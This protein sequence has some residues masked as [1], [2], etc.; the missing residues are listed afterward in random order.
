MSFIK[1][2][3]GAAGM[4]AFTS[5]MAQAAEP[6]TI[7]VVG[8]ITGPAAGNGA[9]MRAGAIAAADRINAQGGIHGQKLNLRFEDDACS[10]TQAI[11]VANRIIGQ[12]DKFVVGHYCSNATLP[13]SVIYDENGI[14]QITLSQATSITQQ[15]FPRLFRIT[16]SAEDLANGYITAVSNDIK[17]A[18]QA[19]LAL[20][21]NSGEYA[22]SIAKSL[23]KSLQDKG[24]ELNYTGHYPPEDTDYSAVITRMRGARITH[25]M[26]AGSEKEMGMIVRQSAQHGFH[27]S[28]ILSS[29]ALSAGFAGIVSCGGNGVRAVAAD[30]PA[31]AAGNEAL[32]ADLLRHGA[33]GLDVAMFSYTA[34]E[35][36]AQAF[37][38]AGNTD[39]AAVSNALHTRTFDLPTG[40]TGFTASGELTHPRVIT[41][42]YQ[43]VN[44][45][46][47]HV[48]P[49]PLTP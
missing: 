41:Y 48:K 28:F 3:F 9:D 26:I 23:Q 34:V 14:V 39:A 16:P 33:N 6:Y 40:K 42:Q 24:I 43:S 2:I 19:K 32:K 27:P 13:A 29:T 11:N 36:F 37:K 17:A 45:P 20:I 47:T 38:A 49:V 7:T 25:V 8:P 22:Q 1:Y 21:G 5:G 31:Y 35:A 12:G 10:E 30:N 4:L 18:A 15:N 46:C 44:T